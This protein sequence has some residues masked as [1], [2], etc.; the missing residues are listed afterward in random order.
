MVRGLVLFVTACAVTPT[1]PKP[2]VARTAPA[3]LTAPDTAPRLPRDFMPLRYRARLAITQGVVGHMEIDGDVRVPTSLIWLDAD[4]LVILGAHAT[5]GHR[6]ITLA[7]QRTTWPYRQTEVL[8]LRS[9]EALGRGHWT[10]TVDYTAKVADQE[11]PKLPFADGDRTAAT[12]HV[13]R[14]TV[15][16]KPYVF[17]MFEPMGARRAFPCFDEPDLKVPWELTLDVA[18]DAVAVSNEPIAS[19]TNGERDRKLVRFAPTKPLPS[20][21]VAFAVGPFD[22]VATATSRGGIPV[23][24]LVPQGHTASIRADVAAFAID[25]L[26]WWTGVKYPFTKADFVAVPRTGLHWEAMENAGVVLHAEYLADSFKTEVMAH[27]LAHHW[28]GNDVTMTWWNDVWL[29]EAFASYLGV[30][31][32]DEFEHRTTGA[33]EMR[34]DVFEDATAQ[35]L[36]AVRAPD[37]KF[38]TS[39]SVITYINGRHGAVLLDMVERF[40][41]EPALRHALHDY[42]V[43]HAYG[44]ATTADLMASLAPVAAQLKPTFD[45]FL[46]RAEVPALT[47]LVNCTGAPELDIWTPPLERWSVPVCVAYDADGK[48]AEQCALVSNTVHEVA[49]HAHACPSWVFPDA[50]AR[51]LYRTKSSHDQLAALV[52]RG[53]PQLTPN[54]QTSLFADGPYNELLS[55]TPKLVAYGDAV[56]LRSAARIL[57]SAI[58]RVPAWTV[59]NPARA[60]W[61]EQHFG[62]TAR[63]LHLKLDRQG[64]YRGNWA[65]LRLAAFAHDPDLGRE[66]VAQTRDRLDHPDQTAIPAML[67]DPSL[68]TALLAA[69]SKDH[70]DSLGV[71]LAEV[72]AALPA[73]E[74]DPTKLAMFSPAFRERIIGDT[75]DPAT[76]DRAIRLAQAQLSADSATR[77]IETLDACIASRHAIDAKLTAALGF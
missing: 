21:A 2:H 74:Q 77:A 51:G 44:N 7:T 4:E 66:A 73:L 15:D 49:L 45:E 9:P 34:R 71:F 52:E 63:G 39:D 37:S 53:W 1:A 40:V 58:D 22:V 48:R 65:I 25:Y 35:R 68:A 55:L 50:G 47:Y 26:E 59:I 62:P 6:T 24:M 18:K 72:P 33:F 31:I 16:G 27:E 5:D 75:C 29:N 23:R 13:F 38:I 56:A 20:Y 76:R 19:E 64:D 42:L 54:E 10:I 67:A 30:K 57:S 46:A 28:F 41:G 3:E 69:A 43:A 12:E 36:A 32:D 60:A 70:A 61:L 17:T 14:E 11:V 8:A